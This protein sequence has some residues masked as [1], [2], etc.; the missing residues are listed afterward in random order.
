MR[1]FAYKTLAGAALGLFLGHRELLACSVCFG[2]PNSKTTHGIFAAVYLLLGLVILVLGGIAG[3][4]VTWARRAK[5]V[6]GAQ[7]RTS[8]LEKN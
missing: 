5:N 4:A 1:H 2:D 6:A 3:T 7:L 8:R